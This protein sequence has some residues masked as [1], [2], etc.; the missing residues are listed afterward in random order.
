MY[1]IMVHDGA[2]APV[3]SDNGCVVVVVKH[4]I[5]IKNNNNLARPE[6]HQLHHRYQVL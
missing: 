6:L 3:V 1:F 4:L 5:I 2:G